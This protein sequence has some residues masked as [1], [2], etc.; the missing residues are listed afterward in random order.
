MK[1]KQKTIGAVYGKLHSSS[2]SVKVH[3]RYKK[4]TIFILTYLESDTTTMVKYKVDANDETSMT[5]QM[6]QN[7]TIYLVKIPAYG[8]G[9]QIGIIYPVHFYT[10]S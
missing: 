7:L 2:P 9:S 5:D 10:K 1:M 8:V 3:E 6:K 4:S